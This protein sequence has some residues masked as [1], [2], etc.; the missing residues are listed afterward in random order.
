[1]RSDGSLRIIVSML[2]EILS[3]P[4]ARSAGMAVIKGQLGA[5]SVNSLTQH[6]KRVGEVANDLYI[7]AIVFINF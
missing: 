2:F 1:M 4:G 3:H 6:P 7:D 5:V